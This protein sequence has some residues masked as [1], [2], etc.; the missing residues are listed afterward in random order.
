MRDRKCL[1]PA[2]VLLSLTLG[3]SLLACSNPSAEAAPTTAHTT[4][5]LV[6]YE[7]ARPFEHEDF[8]AIPVLRIG[9]DGSMEV[10][11]AEMLWGE[12][13][14]EDYTREDLAAA[15]L[16][17]WLAGLS[18]ASQKKLDPDAGVMHPD[19]E[20]ML[21]A[22]E[23]ADV[24]DVL[25]V[26]EACGLKGVNLWRF[27]LG[28]RGAEQEDGTAPLGVLSLEQRR[29]REL[30]PEDPE[31]PQLVLRRGT[32]GVE[33]VVGDA[34]STPREARAWVSS[35]SPR[36]VELQVDPKLS[37]KELMEHVASIGLAGRFELARVP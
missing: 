31:Q 26:V 18:M 12:A 28:V 21:L 24:G 27:L 35:V 8:Y 13:E 19:G 6:S 34:V 32:D 20:F 17:R 37:W 22:E 36:I 15:D 1:F 23:E 10:W 4:T 29:N 25:R 9:G 5:D 11:V 30:E 16:E 33:V 2:T 14:L 7:D 3:T